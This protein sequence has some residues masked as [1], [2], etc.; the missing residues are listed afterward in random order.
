ML[1]VRPPSRPVQ[2]ECTNSACTNIA[3]KHLETSLYPMILPALASAQMANTVLRYKAL[4]LLIQTALTALLEDQFSDLRF[5]CKARRSCWSLLQSQSFSQSVCCLIQCKKSL[6]C[7]LV[8]LPACKCPCSPAG[9]DVGCLD[10]LGQ[11]GCRL[12]GS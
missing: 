4:G 2:A 6:V 1:S 12:Q 3:P 5:H 11:V 10:T 8:Q 9:H 7:R